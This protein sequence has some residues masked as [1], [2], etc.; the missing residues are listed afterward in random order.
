MFVGVALLVLL[1]VGAAPATAQGTQAG[2]TA[3]LSWTSLTGL[4]GVPDAA[5]ADAV[6]KPGFLGGVFVILPLD[7]RRLAQTVAFQA[8][9]LVTQK[10]VRTHN[11][12]R[13][14]VDRTVEYVQFPALVRFGTLGRAPG[15][16]VVAGPA[17][18]IRLASHGALD[19]PL[20]PRTDIGLIAG[21]GAATGEF[22][23]EVRYDAGL[24]GPQKTRAVSTLLHLR[25]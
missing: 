10:G 12:N 16:F 15:P 20:A 22:T 6:W 21:A 8:E 23:I 19:L 9:A 14:N 11:A 25:F 18:S 13:D 24:R 7:R 1:F 5:A 4:A 3:G 2:V 17:V